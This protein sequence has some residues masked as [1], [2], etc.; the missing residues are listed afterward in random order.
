MF[1]HVTRAQADAILGAMSTVVD[2]DDATGGNGG[3][4]MVEAAAAL[5]F[6][7]PRGAGAGPVDSVRPDQLHAAL[8]DDPA[9]GAH[10]VELVAVAAPAD[11]RVETDRLR[12]VLEYAAVLGVREAWTEV[13]ADVA[14]GRTEKAMTQ[15]V[16]S[17]AATFPG[18]A[19]TDG[20]P[21]MLCYTGRS[22]ADKRLLDRCEGLEGYARGTLGHAFWVHF[23]RH[24][25]RFPGQEGAFNSAFAVPHDGLHVLT[26]YDT[27]MQ[28]ELLVST[29]T[30]EMHGVEALSAH[31]LPV[32]FE[33]HI[34][35]EVNGIGAQRGAL[36]PWKFLYAWRR[37]NATTVDVLDTRWR[38][39]DVAERPLE[40]VRTRYGIPD[41]PHRF[42]ASGP[43]VNLTAEADP[44]VT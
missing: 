21:E 4:Q 38:F 8:G 35:Q 19:G 31:L 28:G 32:I 41:L 5:M 7:T 14:E 44:T 16:R 37:G 23:R 26:G 6:D 25:F 3:R 2:H 18:L 36:D 1:E 20:M 29:F 13:L 34:G 39:F 22:D 40:E 11:G 10:T 9:L 33:W 30:G 43:E 15:M 42:R 12:C 24:G 17:N 27:S